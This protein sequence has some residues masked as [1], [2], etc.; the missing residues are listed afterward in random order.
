MIKCRKQIV[1]KRSIEVLGHGKPSAV[2]PQPP[3]GGLAHRNQARHLLAAP[4]DD[5]LLTG[6]HV[7]QKPR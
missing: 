5:H 4:R 7:F 6:R 1:W 3:P 2:D